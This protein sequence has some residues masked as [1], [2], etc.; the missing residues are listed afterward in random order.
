MEALTAHNFLSFPLRRSRV[1]HSKILAL[2]SFPLHSSQLSLFYCKSLLAY[3]I[4][5]SVHFSSYHW[6]EIHW[7]THCKQVHSL[8]PSMQSCFK[9]FSILLMLLMKV[10]II[11][12]Q[13]FIRTNAHTC[14]A[15]LL[16]IR[17]PIPVH[18][19]RPLPLGFTFTLDSLLV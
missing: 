14:L 17:D 6:V 18:M 3:H 13:R 5:N 7:K 9:R 16:A 15:F 11:H 19:A 4:P 2:K 12:S 8:L 1:S 10:F